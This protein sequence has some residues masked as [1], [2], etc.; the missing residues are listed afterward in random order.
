VRGEGGIVGDSIGINFLQRNPPLREAY[1]T[2]SILSYM[3]NGGL[4][5]PQTDCPATDSSIELTNLT[6]NP[7]WDGHL[8]R[9][10]NL[11]KFF[12][13]NELR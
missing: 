4:D 13:E 2:C 3:V 11:R 8:R 12:I 5:A 9:N 7:L 6:P 10:G 1:R